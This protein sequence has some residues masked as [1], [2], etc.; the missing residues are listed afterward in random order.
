MSDTNEFDVEEFGFQEAV[1]EETPITLVVP[2]NIDDLIA[3]YMLNLF[4][5]F[6]DDS[7]AG[8]LEMS[9]KTSVGSGARE[10]SVSHYVQ[11]GSWQTCTQEFKSNSLKTSYER[12]RS[13]YWEQTAHTPKML[14][15]S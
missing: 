2:D 5:Q 14:T 8:E 13:R 6:K 3:Q 15:S 4:N 7:I 10:L 9:I 12:A 11:V 1:E